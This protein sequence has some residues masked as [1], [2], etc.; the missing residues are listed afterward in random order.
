MDVVYAR[1]TKSRSIGYPA[2]GDGITPLRASIFV[3]YSNDRCIGYPARAKG[4]T[5]LRASIFVKS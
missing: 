3:K 2:P 4:M 5:A 1:C